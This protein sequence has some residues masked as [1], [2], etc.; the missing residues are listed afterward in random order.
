[1]GA[2]VPGADV[3]VLMVAVVGMDDADM[4]EGAPSPLL[5]LEPLIAFDAHPA[6]TEPMPRSTVRAMARYRFIGDR[7]IRRVSQIT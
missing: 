2:V 7:G 5:A 3:V 1:M 4:L 6:G